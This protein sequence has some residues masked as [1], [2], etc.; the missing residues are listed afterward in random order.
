MEEEIK[1][2]YLC[3]EKKCDNCSYPDCKYTFDIKHAKNF[4]KGKN[5]VY[6]EQ[7][8]KLDLENEL[9]LN[10]V[11]DLLKEMKRRLDD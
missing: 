9:M 10:E 2:A 3:D 11:L 5:G 6:E 7:E 1:I 4:K 8:K